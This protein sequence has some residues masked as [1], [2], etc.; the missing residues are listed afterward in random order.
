MFT[1][2]ALSDG[3]HFGVLST[4]QYNNIF[5]DCLIVFVV[6]LCSTPSTLSLSL[7]LCVSLFLSC[8]ARESLMVELMRETEDVAAKRKACVEMRELL[9]RALE[10]VN[11]VSAL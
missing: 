2:S 11:E 6:L 9:Q 5:T 7:S 4:A 1:V 8:S 10:I 3:P